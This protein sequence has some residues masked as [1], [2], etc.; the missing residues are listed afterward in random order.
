MRRLAPLLA[1]LASATLTACTE[2]ADRTTGVITVDGFDYRT[3]TTE[4]VDDGRRF[5]KTDV[6]VH[7]HKVGCNPTIAGTCEEAVRRGQ[8][9]MGRPDDT[10]GLDMYGYYPLQ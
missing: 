10:P 8:W 5:A 4:I 3:V 1:V 9:I 7:G 2:V 6:L